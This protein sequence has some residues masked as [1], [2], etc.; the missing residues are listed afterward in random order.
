MHSDR[1]FDANRIL[2][3]EVNFSRLSQMVVI[4][5]LTFL[6][7]IFHRRLNITFDYRPK[8]HQ[9]NACCMRTR[10]SQIHE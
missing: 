8:E 10:S 9:I 7:C 6:L 4:D 5:F 2:L 1:E 3:V